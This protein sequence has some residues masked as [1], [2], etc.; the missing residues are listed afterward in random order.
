[1]I[2]EKMSKDEIA[3]ALV[4]VGVT[5]FDFNSV[6]PSHL[7]GLQIGIRWDGSELT[8]EMVR[9]FNRAEVKKA[10]KLGLKRA[11]PEYGYMYFNGG[12]FRV[13]FA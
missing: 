4:A 6:Y 7:H 5:E 12:P 9:K 13:W 11:G 1:M 8:Y 10:K 2:T 3:A